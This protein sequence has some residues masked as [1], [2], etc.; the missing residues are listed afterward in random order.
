MYPMSP[1]DLKRKKEIF[2]FM[3]VCLGVSVAYLVTLHLTIRFILKHPGDPNNRWV[4]AALIGAMLLGMVLAMRSLG[5]MDEL[6]R[7][8]HT[9][10]MAFAFLASLLIICTCGFLALAGVMTLSLS[11]I[12]PVMVYSWI[13]GLLL[14]LKRYR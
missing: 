8:M 11:L 9:E 13:V 7:K 5:R 14:A 4:A 10:A 3:A 12:A 6:E 2:K 1:L